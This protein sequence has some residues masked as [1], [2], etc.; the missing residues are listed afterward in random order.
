MRPRLVMPHVLPMQARWGSGLGAASPSPP[1]RVRGGLCSICTTTQEQPEV[2]PG[3]P[4]PAP[5]LNLIAS[6]PIDSIANTLLGYRPELYCN[7]TPNWPATG[8]V[9]PR[10]SR[11]LIREPRP[12]NPICAICTFSCLWPRG[13]RDSRRR[14]QT[15]RGSSAAAMEL[16]TP[17]HR[18]PSH[19]SKL[20]PAAAPGRP[21][22]PILPDNALAPPILVA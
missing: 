17:S 12:R 16:G 22:R 20:S 11:R 9:L 4:T 8:P 13:A 14:P 19:P 2:A 1:Y 21:H 18:A 3:P 7:T 15:S 10:A 5:S 6:A